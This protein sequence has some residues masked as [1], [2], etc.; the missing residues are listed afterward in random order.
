MT[1]NQYDT[2][3]DAL[4]AA[5]DKGF[6][7]RF[8]VEKGALRC[9]ENNEIFPASR[10]TIEAYHRVEGPSD[11]DESA[12]LYLIET[13]SG[14]KGTVI[15]A[16]GTYANPEI[17]ELISSIPIDRGDIGSRYEN[18]RCLNCGTILNGMYC[19]HCGQRDEHLHEPFWKLAGHFVGD[20][21]HF[22]SKFSHTL[23]PLLIKPG[24]LTNEF[25]AGKRARYM[26]PVALYFFI[27]VL[28]FLLFFMF[29]NPA[30]EIV[31]G[32]GNINVTGRLDS[33]QV[34]TISDSLSGKKAEKADTVIK[35]ASGGKGIH[36]RPHRAG[37]VAENDRRL[38]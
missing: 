16:F 30:D 8:L 34:G 33:A 9:L 15:D 27:S 1:E 23:F 6:E 3:L 36:F 13:K 35:I 18:K 14:I 22:D 20:L 26:K 5:R 11:P 19:S 7:S 4:K 29:S 37:T 24:F 25:M 12:I 38:Q 28:F 17:A 21:F 2:I 31:G 10:V 32:I